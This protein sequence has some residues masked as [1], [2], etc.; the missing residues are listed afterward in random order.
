MCPTSTEDITVCRQRKWDTLVLRNSGHFRGHCSAP[1][2]PNQPSTFFWIPYSRDMVAPSSRLIIAPK[3][4]P[5]PPVTPNPI[6]ILAARRPVSRAEWYP[7]HTESYP[8]DQARSKG[9]DHST[10]S[11]GADSVERARTM[12]AGRQLDLVGIAISA[13]SMAQSRPT[14]NASDDD[15]NLQRTTVLKYLVSLKIDNMPIYR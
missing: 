15:L 11:F 4:V 8:P 7:Q 5:S 2:Y 6:F 13:R 9:I 1:D 10:D 14:R 12:P 3:R